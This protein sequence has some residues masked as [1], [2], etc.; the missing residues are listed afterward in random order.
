MV[1]LL[2]REHSDGWVHGRRVLRDH[3]TLTPIVVHVLM[4]ELRLTTLLLLSLCL[5]Q[6]ETAP[7]A[8]SRHTLQ[9]HMQL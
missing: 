6:P 2:C 3:P 1:L 9:A 8:C 5:P 7:G 4:L